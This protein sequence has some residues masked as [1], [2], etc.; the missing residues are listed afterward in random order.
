MAKKLGPGRCVHCGI[1]VSQRTWDHVFPRGWYPEDSPKDVEKWKIPACRQCNASYGLI[2]EELGIIIPLCLG[3]DAPNAKGMYEK[4]LR[5]LDPSQGRNFKDRLRREKKRQRILQEMIK[6]NAIP[7]EGAYPGLEER[8]G[9]PKQDQAALRVDA[10]Y[11]RRVVEKIIKG[12]TY[13]EDNRYLDARTEIEHHVVAG[14]GAEPIEQ[15]LAR[16]GITHSR[17]P[18]I[19]V[20]RAVT[21]DDGISS[22]YKITIWG[23]FVMYASVIRENAKKV[24]P[25]NSFDSIVPRGDSSF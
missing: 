19:E 2:E 21:P 6:G 22:L 7:D 12:I 10:E 3:P 23:Q 4:A 13:I 20:M 17:E 11:L 24:A 18:G 5:A 14:E 15:V 8:W 9:R 25:D 1:E 16:Y